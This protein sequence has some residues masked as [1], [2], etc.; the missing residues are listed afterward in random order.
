MIYLFNSACKRNYFAN[1]YRLVGKPAGIRQELRYTEGQNS[2]PV[3]TDRNY[4]KSAC[5]ICYVDRYADGGYRFYP[6]RSGKI[7]SISRTQGRIYYEVEL[8]QHCHA[9]SPEE[10]TKAFYANVDSGPRL[11][12]SNPESSEDGVYCVKGPDLADLVRCTEDSWSHAI[13]QIYGTFAFRFGAPA[14]FLAEVTRRRKAPP[15][16]ELGLRLRA[17][18]QYRITI[19]YRLD[20]EPAVSSNRKILIRAGNEINHEYPVDSRTDRIQMPVSLPPTPFTTGTISIRT[21]VD[22]E[23]SSGGNLGYAVDIPF[24]TRS[25]P[26]NLIL[27]PSLFAIIYLKQA[28]ESGWQFLNPDTW[29]LSAAEF[30]PFAVILW[31]IYKLKG[32]A[33]LMGR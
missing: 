29:L 10:F 7:S 21:S 2:P 33:R 13:D 31:A 15:S 5:T 20:S 8:G 22:T 9:P 26:V 32:P 4:L 3:S 17:N 14:F 19:L 18:T 28:W 6:F 1:V 11:V 16:D 12:E 23:G 27:L 24:R 25:R 30:A